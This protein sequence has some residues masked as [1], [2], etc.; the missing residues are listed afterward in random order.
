MSCQTKTRVPTR[1]SSIQTFNLPSSLRENSYC[2]TKRA[3][4]T[5]KYT[6][7]RIRITQSSLRVCAATTIYIR[8]PAP[9]RQGSTPNARRY[10]FECHAGT[11]RGIVVVA[12]HRRLR[13]L[14]FAAG[15]FSELFAFCINITRLGLSTIRLLTQTG[16]I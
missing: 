13:C 8:L 4:R 2:S 1:V 7:T 12:F 9:I 11:G 3:A 15:P 10:R 14:N 16:N 5:W 6:H